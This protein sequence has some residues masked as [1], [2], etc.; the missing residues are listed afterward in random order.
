LFLGIPFLK[1]AEESKA[2][3]RLMESHEKK[4]KSTFKS[5]KLDTPTSIKPVD[6]KFLQQTVY[7]KLY[8]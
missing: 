1:P 7:V 6:E 8:R 2:L 3:D 4:Q 5:D